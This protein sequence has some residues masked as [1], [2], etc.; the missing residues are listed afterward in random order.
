[1]KGNV[2]SREKVLI[3]PICIIVIILAIGHV[4]YNNV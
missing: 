4:E 3:M 1:M 2:M